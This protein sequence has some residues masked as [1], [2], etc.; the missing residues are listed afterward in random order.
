MQVF[1]YTMK[2]IANMMLSC[3]IQYDNG[4]FL[5]VHGLG[6][7]KLFLIIMVCSV[8][9]TG[10]NDHAEIENTDEIENSEVTENE[11]SI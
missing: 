6:N 3:D 4:F 8:L 1:S 7:W 10:C 2:Q 5:S 9:V 11:D